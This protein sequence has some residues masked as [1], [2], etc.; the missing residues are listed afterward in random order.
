MIKNEKEL[1]KWFRDFLIDNGIKARKLETPFARGWSDIYI[2][3]NGL[4]TWA[5]MKWLK[6]QTPELVRTEMATLVK[7]LPTALQRKF[8]R[9]EFANGLGALVLTGY[10][11]QTDNPKAKK[12]L[13]FAVEYANGEVDVC[14]HPSDILTIIK[15]GEVR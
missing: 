5:E 6:I 9:D 8:L 13:W 12:Q 1:Q 15:R 4:V 3:F 7:T 10:Y 14:K 11:I 2:P